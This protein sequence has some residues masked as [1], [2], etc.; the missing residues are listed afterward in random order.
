MAPMTPT[1]MPPPP[2]R[3][4]AS[5][6]VKASTNEMTEQMPNKR[7]AHVPMDIGDQGLNIKPEAPGVVLS[8]I[9]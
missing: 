7:S 9:W 3:R 1:I 6:M 2:G 5:L 4:A 8:S